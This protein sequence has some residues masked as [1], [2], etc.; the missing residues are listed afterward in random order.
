[1]LATAGWEVVEDVEWS[2]QHVFHLRAAGAK[3]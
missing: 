3:W 2:N 1:M